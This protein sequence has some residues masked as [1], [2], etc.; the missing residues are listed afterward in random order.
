MSFEI[1]ET[2]F[3]RVTALR[4]FTLRSLALLRNGQARFKAFLAVA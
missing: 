4:P 3:A 2:R 1:R